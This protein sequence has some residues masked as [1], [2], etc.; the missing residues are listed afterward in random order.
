M[1]SPS[2][3]ISRASQSEEQ[4]SFRQRNT[5]ANIAENMELQLRVT[6]K[7]VKYDRRIETNDRHGC[8]LLHAESAT[9]R[10]NRGNTP[11]RRSW[12]RQEPDHSATLGSDRRATSTRRSRLL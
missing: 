6:T 3:S 7:G 1:Q 10:G 9:Q 4:R 5:L 12:N 2:D 8:A 11:V